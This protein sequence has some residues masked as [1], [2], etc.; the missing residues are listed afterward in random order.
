MDDNVDAKVFVYQHPW[1]TGSFG[2]AMDCVVDHQIFRQARFWSLD[3]QFLDH[4]DPE[5]IFF[6]RERDIKI[7]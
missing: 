5:W 2:S 1:D 3:G 4:A 6:Q 7:R